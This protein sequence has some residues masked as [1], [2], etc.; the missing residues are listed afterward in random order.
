[1]ADISSSIPPNSLGEYLGRLN[2]SSIENVSENSIVLG[3]FDTFSNAD[4][5]QPDVDQHI[6]ISNNSSI[7]E[8]NAGR[9]EER[10]RKVFLIVSVTCSLSLVIFLV[11]LC[12]YL[13]NRR[14]NKLQD[15]TNQNSTDFDI[16]ATIPREFHYKELAAATNGFANNRKLGQG[17]S[18][19]VYK[20]VLNDLGRV[21]AVKRI[22]PEHGSSKRIFI[23]EVKIISRLI[24]RN[25]V[26]FIGWCHEQGE[27]LLVFEYMS[28]GSLDT[29]LF[30]H[31]EILPWNIRYNIAQGVVTALPYLH[32]EAEQCVLHR[33]VKS[34]N[35]MLD[36]DFNAKLGDF[37]IAKLINT[38]LNTHKTALVGTIGYIAPEY[39]NEGRATKAL[40]IY[41]FGIVALKIACGR[42]TH[43]EEGY[44]ISLVNWVWKL[45]VEGNILNAADERLN[46]D[47]DVNEMKCLL[48][49]GLWCTN[50]NDKERPQASQVINVLHHEVSL[51]T[52]PNN[53][54]DFASCSNPIQGQYNSFQSQPITTTLRSVGR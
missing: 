50:P 8:S 28:N 32:D 33:D 21:I 25:V 37:G 31:K 34:A 22:S 40:D 43:V 53:L 5:D 51:P 13:V 47:F 16:T 29:H 3:E 41:S 12:W 35:V 11:C 17:G 38:K 19:Q 46:M 23:N 27:L 18:G 7:Y 15:N 54:H 2:T 10:K 39:I 24:H 9:S 44:H 45:Y 36:T 6:E 42:K 20:G 30:G 1:M 52:L 14:R 26:Q 49:V 48:T 4:F